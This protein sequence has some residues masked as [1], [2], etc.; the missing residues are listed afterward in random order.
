MDFAH[1][2]D[3]LRQDRELAIEVYALGTSGYVATAV[4]LGLVLTRSRW[5]PHFAAAFGLAA[6]VGFAAV[7]LAP[8]WSPFSDPYSR[9]DADALSYVLVAAPMLSALALAAT[10]VRELREPRALNLRAVAAE[11]D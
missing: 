3:H 2:L 11:V 8:H 1:F 5:A 4:L 9:F 7:H 10:G 6:L